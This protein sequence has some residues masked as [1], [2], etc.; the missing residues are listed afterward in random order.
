[1]SDIFYLL[2]ELKIRIYMI[3]VFLG[4]VTLLIK[5]TIVIVFIFF[6]VTY[7]VYNLLNMTLKVQS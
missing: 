1:M 5:V 6:H 2:I 4:R 7:M 3:T